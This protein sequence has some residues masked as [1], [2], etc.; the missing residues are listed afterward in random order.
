VNR[1]VKDVT[2]HDLRA[3]LKTVVARGANRLAVV[4]FNDTRQMFAWAER[5]QPWRRLLQDANPAA[6]IE[7]TRS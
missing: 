3:A 2:E 6:L 5:R 4:L 1:L 7:I